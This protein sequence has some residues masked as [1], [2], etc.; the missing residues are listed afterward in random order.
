[1]QVSWKEGRLFES[2]NEE[3]TSILMDVLKSKGGS[4]KGVT[5]VEATIAA[6]AACSG[7]DMVNI[8]TK[9]RCNIKSLRIQADSTQAPQHPMYF[10]WMK[11]TY[12]ISGEN[13]DEMKVQKA[14][15]LSMD[16]YCAVKA[17]MADK[18]RVETEIV[19]E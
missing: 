14:I 4:G 9:M 17:S 5:P 13:I 10:D 1:M 18:C 12:Y 8:L 11:F 19:I 2:V 15:D 6:A 16:K 3:G 7:I